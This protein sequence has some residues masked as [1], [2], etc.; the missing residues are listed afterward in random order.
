ML[1][2]RDSPEAYQGKE[3]E[4]QQQNQHP[5]LHLLQEP[6]QG[7]QPGHG[8]NVL[9]RVHDFELG[10][11]L[12]DDRSSAPTM[13]QGQILITEVRGC[14]ISALRT[15]QCVTS[16][17]QGR[18]QLRHP[19]IITVA[20]NYTLFKINLA[21]DFD[22]FT[23]RQFCSGNHGYDSQLLQRLGG[24]VGVGVAWNH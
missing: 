22:D 14:H 17:R 23:Q 2:I 9:L 21:P 5:N 6:C 1:W 7:L 20:V 3:R 24:Q 16:P 8:L 13:L 18:Q 11:Q 12:G 10:P 4:K 15:Q 19:L